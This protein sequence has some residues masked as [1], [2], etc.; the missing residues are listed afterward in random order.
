MF[1]CLL[2]TYPPL[3][4]LQAHNI[5]NALAQWCSLIY[6]QNCWPLHARNGRQQEA[7]I[8]AALIPLHTRLR[9]RSRQGSLLCI[10]HHRF[11]QGLSPN[12]MGSARGYDSIT[13]VTNDP[14]GHATGDTG[15]SCEKN[16]PWE[17]LRRHATKDTG[18]TRSGE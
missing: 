16:G 10:A 6:L 12:H 4:D 7:C 14:R 5:E 9:Q 15:D 11:C 17:H 13:S 8:L 3:N 2:T 1:P 18:D